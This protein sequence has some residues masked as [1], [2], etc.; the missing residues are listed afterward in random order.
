MTSVNDAA[1]TMIMTTTRCAWYMPPRHHIHISYLKI[2]MMGHQND[3][4][5]HYHDG[6][7]V[8]KTAHGGTWMAKP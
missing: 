1:T 8:T 2:A 5:D 3:E 7:S 6:G 4:D